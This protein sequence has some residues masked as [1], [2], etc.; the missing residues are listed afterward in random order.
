MDLIPAEVLEE[1]GKVLT[2]GAVKYGDNN[3]QD[4]HIDRYI[5]A[6]L[7][8]Y[9]AWR[10]GEVCDNESGLP[11]TSHMLANIAFIVYKESTRELDEFEG[12]SDIVT[13][14]LS[15]EIEEWKSTDVKDNEE[16]GSTTIYFG[17]G[18]TIKFGDEDQEE[19]LSEEEF[20]KRV[21][22]GE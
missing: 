4:V 21:K 14:R 10:K 7:R 19:I 2:M 12:L 11:H 9:I 8:H 22:R 20:W 16:K 5:S 1:L 6:L 3:W 18:S 15:V 17:N 13:E